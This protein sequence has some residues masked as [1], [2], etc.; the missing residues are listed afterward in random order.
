[1]RNSWLAKSARH[2]AWSSPPCQSTI[3]EHQQ[4]VED[5]QHRGQALREPVGE[6]VMRADQVL[7][8]RRDHH[9]RIA[10][11]SVSSSAA[12]RRDRRGLARGLEIEPDVHVHQ[13]VPEAR[14]TG[15]GDR[16]TPAP[17]RRASTSGRAMN[18]RNA[19]YASGEA[20]LACDAPQQRRNA[21]EEQQ[22]AADPVQD[23]RDRR[24]RL[25]DPRQVEIDRARL[26]D[27]RGAASSAAHGQSESAA[28]S[29][30]ASRPSITASTLAT[31]PRRGRRNGRRAS[32]G[33]MGRNPRTC[34]HAVPAR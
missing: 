21:D 19:S 32:A 12:T 7:A 34:P 14:R 18:A 25:P 31:G 20:R 29:R 9:R 11:R 13:Q 5:H 26:R 30:L 8:L 1:M 23:R 4:R 24:N 17:A 22:R 15:D 2:V 33:G 10:T 16:P 3:A 6:A 27:G 28:R